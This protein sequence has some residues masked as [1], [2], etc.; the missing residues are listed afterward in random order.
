MPLT[1]FSP[2]KDAKYAVYGKSPSGSDW[3]EY[4]VIE[5]ATKKTLDDTLQWVKVSNV[6]WPGD[7]FFYS[8][9]PAPDQAKARAGINENHQVYFHRVGTP[10][11]QDQLVYS[12]PAHPQRF[13]IVETTDDERFAVL[14]ISERGK[15]KDGNAL[16]VSDLAAGEKEFKPLGPDITDFRFDVVDNVGDKLLVATNKGAPNTRGPDRPEK[17][18]G[19]ELESRAPRTAGATGKRQH[20]RRE[21]FRDLSQGRDHSRL[22]AQRWTDASRA[23]LCSRAPARPLGSAA[24]ATTRSCSTR[25]IR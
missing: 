6:A 19:G 8:R 20:R 14:S 2:S 11:S 12:D 15:G 23:R 3:Q 1:T 24:S 7:G 18:G 9:Y 16:F 25:S 13:H 5:L 4:H 21:D 22:C 17:A 10:Q